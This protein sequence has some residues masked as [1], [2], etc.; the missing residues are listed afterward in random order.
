MSVTEKTPN[1]TPHSRLEKLTQKI[2]ILPPDFYV[3]FYTV[4]NKP[5]QLNNHPIRKLKNL[6]WLES[7][8][9][10]LSIKNVSLTKNFTVFLTT[11]INSEPEM[12]KDTEIPTKVEIDPMCSRL[13]QTTAV[14]FQSQFVS[15]DFTNPHMIDGFRTR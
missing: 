2:N 12:L 7:L 11:P 10:T 9:S 15:W 6:R 4:S 8:L 3:E 1:V 13:F 5:V 14:T